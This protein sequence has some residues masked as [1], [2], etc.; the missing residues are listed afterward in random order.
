MRVKWDEFSKKYFSAGCSNAVC[1]SFNPETNSYDYGEAWNG[2]TKFTDNPTGAEEQSFYA[3]NKKY[4]SIRGVENYG[5]SVGCYT[6]PDNFKKCLGKKTVAQGVTVSQQKRASFGF[7]VTTKVGND[8]SGIDFGETIHIVWNASTS[9]TSR[10]YSSLNENPTPTE[11]SFECKADP[12]EVEAD[13]ISPTCNMEICCVG[14]DS[15]TLAVV[16][17]LK[18]ILY[19]TEDND[20]RLPMPDEIIE[21]FSGLSANYIYWGVAPSTAYVS[22]LTK[23]RSNN[24]ARTITVNAEEGEYIIYAYPSRLGPVEF[25]YGMFEGG[26]EDPITQDITNTSG[27]TEEYYIYRSTHANLGETTLVIK[28]A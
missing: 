12:V 10:D 28:E 22:V 1:Y 3:N 17:Q 25:W 9:P 23:E 4:I 27:E 18:D 7:V 8:V 24:P 26:F 14:M 16:R 21:M 13:G 20:P 11:M 6:F 15:E 2:V 19:G 5:F